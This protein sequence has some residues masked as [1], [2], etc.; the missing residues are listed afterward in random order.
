MNPVESIL[1]E[2]IDKPESLFIFPTDV[3]ASCWADH[4]LRIRGSTIAMDKFTAWDTFKQ[5]SVKSRMQ[6]KKSVPSALRKIFAGRLVRENAALCGQGTP[7]LFSS[8]IPQKW[9][10]QAASFTGWITD[11]LPQLGAWF[12]KTTRL[13]AADITG[14]EA[15]RTAEKFE[16]D[17]RDLY[18]LALRYALFLEEHGLF[19]PA[20]EKPPFDDTGKNCFIFFPESLSDFG[21]YRELLSN[22]GHVTMISGSGGAAEQSSE[23]FYYTNSRSEIAGAALYIRALHEKKHIPWDSISVSIPG[24]E[25]YEPYVLREFTSRNIP[26]VKRTGKPLASYPAGQFFRAVAACASN[27]FSFSSLSELLLNR[28]LPWKEPDEIQNLIDFGIKNNCITSWTESEDEN[29]QETPVNVWEDA[30]NSPFSRIAP[31]TR[32]FF[33]DLKW[34]V[35]ALRRAK[36]FAVLRKYYFTFRERFFDMDNCLPETDIVLSR[37]ISELIYLTELE[38]SFPDVPAPDPY[39][40]FTEHLQEVSYLTQQTAS[41][42][43]ILPYRTAAPAPFDCHIILGAAQDSLSV[44]FSRMSFLPGGK[45]KKLNLVDEDASE[46]YINLHRL[47]S[48]M[49][50]AFFCA[51]Q[52]FSGYAIPHSM[53]NAPLKPRRSYADDTELQ[54][55]FSDDLPDEE[56]KFYRK[57][58]GETTAHPVF[59]KRLHENQKTGFEAWLSRRKAETAGDSGWTA[60]TALLELIRAR[61]CGNTE[62]PGRFSVSASSLAPYFQCSLKWLFGRV[63]MLENVQV[64][65]GLMEKN[66]AGTVYHAVLNNF[67]TELKIIDNPLKAPCHPGN[68]PKNRIV[69]PDEYRTALEQSIDTVFNALPCIPP[70]DYPAMSALGARLLRA[71]KKQFYYTLEHC[72]AVFLLWFNGFRIIESEKKYCLSRALGYLNGTV[73]CMLEDTRQTSETKGAVVI[74]DFKLKH[75]PERDDCTGTG[76]NGLAN[77]QLPMYLTLAEANEKKSIDSALFFSIVDAE[78]EVLFGV[79]NDLSGGTVIPKKEDDRIM[80]GS[81]LFRKIMDEFEEKAKRFAE[82]MSSGQFS[83]YAAGFE[84][85]VNCNYLRV[86]RTVYRINQEQNL[87]SWGNGNGT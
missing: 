12:T 13:T 83:V 75:L 64:E 29:G 4:L 15:A 47:N 57:L 30:F 41:G 74:V 55:K 45:R 19:E 28:H 67:F 33:E 77:F 69:L 44:I 25:T 65:T 7:P 16:A 72:L 86:C 49:P 17:D 6:N 84:K 21:E 37:C 73:D 54:S 46:V 62:F 50:A 31:S 10:G 70:A 27:E 22:S 42:V 36:S 18:T 48:K 53:I 9:A 71:E 11:L 60:N 82:E 81:A 34:R 78:P 61:F 66:I 80:R 76:E 52:T 79:I 68:G 26:F 58:R 35:N 43:A 39:L 32:H 87:T 20:W 85:C 23:T 51:E 40:F 2:N 38:K 56:S 59:P 14:A 8:L 24:T 63:L 3:A 1:L 5:N